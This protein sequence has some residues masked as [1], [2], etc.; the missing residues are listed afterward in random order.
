[1]TSTGFSVGFS[2]QERSSSK[3]SK[4]PGGPSS[5]IFGPANGHDEH[6]SRPMKNRMQSN[7][8]GAGDASGN[9][10]TPQRRSFDVGDTQDKL[11][12]SDVTDTTPRKVVDRMKSNVFT[13][14]E[15]VIRSYSAKKYGPVRRNPITGEVYDDVSKMNGHTNGHMNGR[16]LLNSPISNGDP[17]SPSDQFI[18]I[19]NPPGGKSSGI[20]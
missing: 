9:G 3:V 10:F 8:F 17:S 14:P 18:R 1:M 15:P 5:D 19:R 6:Q 4:P 20:F 11:F 12:G 2:N 16:E 13:G 7:I